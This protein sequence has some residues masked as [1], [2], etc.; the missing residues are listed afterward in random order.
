MGYDAESLSILVSKIIIS[1][2]LFFTK[3]DVIEIGIE[4]SD[5]RGTN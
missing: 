2:T 4:R 5:Q 1:L 3:V